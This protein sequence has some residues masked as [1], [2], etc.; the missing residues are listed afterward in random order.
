MASEKSLKIL[1][2]DLPCLLFSMYSKDHSIQH[3]LAASP[4]YIVCKRLAHRKPFCY[5]V[6][7]QLGRTEFIGIYTLLS[8]LLMSTHREDDSD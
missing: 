5:L 1:L 4:Q 8:S 7:R 6:L 2:K 3:T